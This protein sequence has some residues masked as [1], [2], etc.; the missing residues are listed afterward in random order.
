[1]PQLVVQEADDGVGQALLV[2]HLE[3]GGDDAGFQELQTPARRECGKGPRR[4]CPTQAHGAPLP[5]QHPCPQA[6]RQA[7]RPAVITLSP[8]EWGVGSWGPQGLKRPPHMGWSPV[9]L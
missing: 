5:R 2:I 3:R 8:A 6:C 1:M 7:E 9:G 4:G